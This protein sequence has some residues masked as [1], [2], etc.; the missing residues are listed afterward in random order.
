MIRVG[1][2]Y[3]IHRLVE[4]RK[5]IIGGVPIPHEKGFEAHSD[6][7]VLCHALSDALLGAAGLPNIGVLFPDTDPHYKNADSIELLKIV[8]ERVKEAGYRP[9]QMDS[10]IVAQRPKLQPFVSAMTGILSEVTGMEESAISIKPRT[11]ERLGAEGR[12]EGISVQ[13]VVL[14]ERCSENAS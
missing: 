1:I 5:L 9:V 13:V 3:D 14:L 2:G 7:D 10:N 4:G 12:E 6:G 11:N 8:L